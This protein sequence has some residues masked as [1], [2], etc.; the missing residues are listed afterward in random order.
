MTELQVRERVVVALT[1]RPEGETLLRRGARIAARG[2]GGQL[3]AV[4]VA[5]SQRHNPAEPA[6]VAR[7]RLLTE[8]LGGSHHTVVAD[9]AAAAVLDFARSVEATQIIV[10]VSR[11]NRLAAGLR[12]GVSD[13]IVDGSGDVDVLVVTHRFARGARNETRAPGVLSR[14]RLAAGW[15]LA[16]VVPPLLTLL[17]VPVRRAASPSFES[18]AFLALTVVCALVGGLWPALFAAVTGCLL[19]NYFF[20]APL[21]TFTISDPQNIASLLLFLLVATAVASVVGTAARRSLQA[22]LARREADTLSMLNHKL[23]GGEVD[24]SALLDLV[25]ET[26]AMES[27]A[28]LRRTPGSLG[29]TVVLA[30]GPRPPAAPDDGDA[31]AEAS[32]TTS[33]VLR[34]RSLP[35]HD[36]RVLAAFATHVSVVLERQ[37]LA[38]RAAAARRLEEGNQ[39]RTALLAAVSHDLRT[40]LAGIKAA[41]TS[42]RSPDVTWSPDDERELLGAI[43]ESADRLDS[44][45]ANLLDMSRLQTGAVHLVTHE[46]GLDEL[47]TRA[48]VDLPGAGAVELDLP[49][50]L[51]TVRVDAG[52]LSRVVANLVEN[53]LRHSP[54][55]GTVRV[56]A[57]ADHERVRLLVVDHGPGVPDAEKAQMFAPF[58]RL[59]DT[60]AGEGV[61]LGLAVAKGLTEALDG[62]L[63]ATDTPGGGLTM[64]ID[65]PA[66]ARSQALVES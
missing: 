60:P 37:E 10:G 17:L 8:E 54:P 59:G 57:D 16:V 58:Q 2:E 28:L 32:A 39:L 25:R 30:R 49:E 5:P 55:G 31:V 51:P 36:L 53:A 38:A 34:G 13:R 20:T 24:V 40:P 47:V 29:W 22:D 48:V 52:L 12:P 63:V 65:L 35:A 26:F 3:H 21:H 66:A 14:R 23:L 1:G 64:V 50:G 44:I 15:A 27:A 6:D 4:Y 61:G 46:V 43:E 19:L 7:L 45:V 41:V 42:L 62:T 56:A 18:L 9:D 33:L 11:R